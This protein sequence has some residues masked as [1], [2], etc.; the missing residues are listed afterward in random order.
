MT[1]KKNFKLFGDR[2]L[3]EKVAPKQGTIY[4]PDN[5]QDI[6]RIGKVVAVGDGKRP[7]LKTLQH[8]GH[9]YEV[10]LKDVTMV[11]KPGDLVYFQTN[12]I[13]QSNCMYDMGSEILMNLAQA[14]IIA[15]LDSNEITL[16]GFHLMPDWVLVRPFMKDEPQGI[17]LPEVAKK[18]RAIYFRVEKMGDN[19][20]KPITPG[21]EVVLTHGYC[22]PIQI[23]REDFGYIHKNEIHGVVEESRIIT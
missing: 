15:K 14:E 20:D 18:A 11:V 6:S 1:K 3:V 22:N 16:D 2:V 13:Q 5:A 9:Y 17:V 10:M 8:N 4:V 23:Q 7:G 12:A 19:V 21:D